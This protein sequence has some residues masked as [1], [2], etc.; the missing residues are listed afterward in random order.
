M[1]RSRPSS[2]RPTRSGATCQGPTVTDDLGEGGSVDVLH[3]PGTACDGPGRRPG[4][5]RCRTAGPDGLVRPRWRTV[6]ESGIARQFRSDDLHRDLA[7]RRC[8]A[9][10]HRPHPALA[11]PAEQAIGAEASRVVG[12]Q[13]LGVTCPAAYHRDLAVWSELDRTHRTHQRRARR[14]PCRG[15]GVA[16]VGLL[17][18]RWWG[19]GSLSKASSSWDGLTSCVGGRARSMAALSAGERR[20]CS[21]HSPWP[22]MDRWLTVFRSP[23]SPSL[24]PRSA[25]AQAWWAAARQGTGWCRQLARDH[26]DVRVMGRAAVARW[27]PG[28][29]VMGWRWP[30]ISTRQMLATVISPSTDSGSRYGDAPVLP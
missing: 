1:H 19:I 25:G 10:V 8:L 11:E 24:P 14:R 12:V 15:R 3:G 13:G 28:W 30:L 26:R 5:R 6:P 4:L 9:E 20:G 18:G 16:S 22:A 2:A 27:R 21:M 23:V 29:R 7:A 17:L